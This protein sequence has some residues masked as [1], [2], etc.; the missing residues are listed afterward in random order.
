VTDPPPVGDGLDGAVVIVTGAAGGLG[1][2]IVRRLRSAG[3]KVV[4]ED[5]APTVSELEGSDGGVAALCGD[6]ALASTAEAAVALA[7]E[8]FGRL[9]VLINNA[10]RV[11]FKSLPDTTDELWD[12]LMATNA[13]GP[14][15]HC[16]AALGH[17]A[18]SP[19]GAIVNVASIS[20]VVGLADQAAYCATK[21]AVVGLTRALAVECAG[22]GVRVNA[23]APGA[24]S[25]PLLLDALRASG[26]LEAGLRQVAAHHPLGRLASPAEIAEVVVFLASPRS[27]FMT[28]SVVLADGGYTAA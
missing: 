4:A 16:R 5:I 2:E 10:G 28:G 22:R 15:V 17:L 18:R 21:G 23:I 6:V 7:L 12:G 24:I 9:D 13:R 26:D 25:T 11:A 19:A 1:L 27:S 8:R 3:S 14:F 20:G